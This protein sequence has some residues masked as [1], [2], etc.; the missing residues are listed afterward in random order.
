MEG[1][2]IFLFPTSPRTF[3]PRIAYPGYRPPPP[4]CLK[5]GWQVEKDW[6]E[7]VK[8]EGFSNGWFFTPSF[9]LIKR[10]RNLGIHTVTT[11]TTDHNKFQPRFPRASRYLRQP[12]VFRPAPVPYMMP[13]GTP[14]WKGRSVWCISN[15]FRIELQFG[16]I[17]ASYKCILVKD[18]VL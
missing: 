2:Q 6:L 17:T 14:C 15:L 3:D 11:T 4:M 5:R 7:R 16:S 12:P 1:Q 8:N 9:K 18:P 13:L 10:R